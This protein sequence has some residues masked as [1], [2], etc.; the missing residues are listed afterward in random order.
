MMFARLG[1]G[2]AADTTE[3]TERL[4][5]FSGRYGF[6]PCSKPD[7]KASLAHAFG[8]NLLISI[9]M[10]ARKGSAFRLSRLRRTRVP[11]FTPGEGLGKRFGADNSFRPRPV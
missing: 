5:S 6:W 4:L 2:T 9:T 1:P 10:L 3:R 11:G 7:S 8:E